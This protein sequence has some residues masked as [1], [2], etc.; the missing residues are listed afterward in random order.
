[1]KISH[2]RL[3]GRLSGFSWASRLS[4]LL[5]GESRLSD[6]MGHLDVTAGSKTGIRKLQ[7]E[8]DQPTD[9]PTGID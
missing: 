9:M 5:L 7:M 2:Q 1:M 6:L 3:A 4:G 8:Q